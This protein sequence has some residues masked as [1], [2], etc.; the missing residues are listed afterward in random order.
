MVDN[1][2]V[3][4]QISDLMKDMFNR[5]SECSNVVEGQCSPEEY[6]AF[7]HS[8]RNITWGIVFD[9]M[10]PLYAKHPDLAPSNWEDISN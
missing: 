10:E 6:R 8:I 7:V 2:L 3:A 5:I 9:V 4:K 1:P